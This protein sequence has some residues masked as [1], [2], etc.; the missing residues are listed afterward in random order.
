MADITTNG[1]GNGNG[2]S[3]RF[4]MTVSLGAV[5]QIITMLCGGAVVYA[6]MSSRIAVLETKVDNVTG[7]VH[8]IAADRKVPPFV[9]GQPQ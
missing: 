6:N 8:A 2:K 7:W 4:Q 3:G 9:A 1:N 5:L